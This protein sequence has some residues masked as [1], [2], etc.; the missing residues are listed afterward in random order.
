MSGGAPAGG[1]GGAR[2]RIKG[3]KGSVIR[4]LIIS[5]SHSTAQHSTADTHPH[6]DQQPR[7]CACSA[8]HD[9]IFFSRCLGPLHH[10]L[11]QHTC[12]NKLLH[13]P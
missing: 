1:G 2:V 8:Q 9:K 13:A 12:T 10:M 7:T 3:R 5:V 11:C 6:A 4:F